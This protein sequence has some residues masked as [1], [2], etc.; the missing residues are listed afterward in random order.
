MDHLERFFD[1]AAAE[2]EQNKSTD[3]I[4]IRSNKINVNSA[5]RTVQNRISSELYGDA[6]TQL[7]RAVQ[8]LANHSPQLSKVRKIAVSL[9]ASRLM[10][11]GL[12]Y[13]RPAVH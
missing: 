3:Q 12:D 4:A 6:Q 5:L 10:T 2:I 9:V 13:C 8:L 1:V 11:V 7:T